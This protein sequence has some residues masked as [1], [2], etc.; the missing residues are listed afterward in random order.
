[1][2]TAD[3]IW[4]DHNTDRADE[5]RPHR[6]PQGHQLPHRVLE[7]TSASNNK[8]FGIGWTDN[9]T[10]RMT[11]HH[12]WIHDTNQRNPSIDNVA[13]AHLYN[14]YLQNI[15]S[16]GNLSRG[17]RRWSSRTATSTTSNDPYTY[18]TTAASLKQSGSI[19]V[20][21]TGEQK[22][23]GTDLHPGQLLR[24]TRSTRPQTSRLC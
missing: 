15:T 17:S 6:Q 8:A 24:A 10:A 4:I 18:D 16:Y 13:L 5:R 1:M 21:C 23:N 20:N 22:T 11:I 19:V 3:H 2:D 7:R 14:N 12:N 9:V